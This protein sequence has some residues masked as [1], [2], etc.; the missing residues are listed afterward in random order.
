MSTIAAPV[1]IVGVARS[2][3]SALYLA[4]QKHPSFSPTRSPHGFDLTESRVFL[5]PAGARVRSGPAWDFLL[6]DDASFCAL[7]RQLSGIPRTTDA[8]YAHPALQRS[9]FRRTVT[10]LAWWKLCRRDFLVRAYFEQAA[11]A[12]GVHRIVEKTPDHLYR[13]AEIRATFPTAHILCTIR[14]PLDVFSSYKRRLAAAMHSEPADSDVVRWLQRM[15]APS[16][17]GYYRSITDEVVHAHAA[18][19]VRYEEFTTEP[20]AAFRRI[21]D[22]LDEPFD[23]RCIEEAT[24]ALQ[25]FTQDPRLSLPVQRNDKRWED[26]ITPN[27]ATHIEDA[28]HDSMSRLGYPRRT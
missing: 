1:F 16:F 2:G 25:D 7:E 4:L 10:R 27:D 23:A 5:E 24:P 12:R 15:D 14:H 9:I 18:L 26:F 13:L 3:T 19:P 8:A 28:L 6:R 22:F 11:R 21:C 20:A 17:I